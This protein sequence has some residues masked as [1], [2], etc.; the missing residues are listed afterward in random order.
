MGNQSSMAQ[1]WEITLQICRVAGS[2]GLLTVCTEG[3]QRHWQTSF[4][5]LLA[6]RPNWA[7]GNAAIKRRIVCST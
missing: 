7:V 1:P 3:F 4:P 6:I 5:E 2:N